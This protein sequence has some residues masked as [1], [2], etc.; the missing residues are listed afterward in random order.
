MVRPDDV[1]AL[2]KPAKVA[3]EAASEGASPKPATRHAVRIVCHVAPA[4]GRSRF[5]E[6]AII[7]LVDATDDGD[8][9]RRVG[10]ALSEL[11]SR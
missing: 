5:V 4:S 9:C 8:A 10:Q 11:V 3:V 1:A 2:M 6:E 7:F